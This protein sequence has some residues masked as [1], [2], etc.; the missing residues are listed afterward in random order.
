MAALSEQAINYDELVEDSG[1]GLRVSG[2]LYHDPQV[3]DDEMEKIFHQ[4][5]VFVGHDSEVAEP[6]EYITRNIGL[7]PVI[8]SRDSEGQVHLLLNR[9][10][11]RSATVCQQDRGNASTFTCAYHGWTYSNKG[12]LIGAPFNGGRGGYDE[13]FKREDYGLM[14]VPR[15]ASHRGFVFGSLSPTGQSFDDYLGLAKSY[16]D[17]F[18]D[19]APEGEVLARA[20]RQKTRYDGNWKLQVENLTDQYHVFFTHQTALRRPGRDATAITMD[21]ARMLQRDLGQG[22]TALDR[23]GANRS[24]GEALNDRITGATGTLDPEVVGRVAERMG[25]EAAEYVSTGGPPHIMVFPNLMVLWNAFRVLQPVRPNLSYIYYYPTFLK[26]ASDEINTQRLRAHENGFG[27]AGF[28]NPD[29]VDMFAR[30]QTGTKAKA[31]DWS[32]LHRGVR[33]EAMEPDDFGQPSLTTQVLGETNQRGIWRH[34]K[35]IMGQAG[36]GSGSNGPLTPEMQKAFDFYLA[37]HDA[38]VE[39]YN[40]KV[41]AIRG[42]EVLRVYDQ[43]LE[44]DMDTQHRGESGLVHLQRVSRDNKTPSFPAVAPRV[45]LP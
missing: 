45:R 26:G 7:Q 4:G 34:Y 2:R 9:C 37:N 43:Y 20:G 40:G 10:R 22:H 25:E 14:P 15:I 33:G 35:K 5:W 41:I 13:S 44:A 42:E 19:M 18:C 24:V 21:D 8:M 31:D 3:F 16:L 27:P 1:N 6:G 38:M 29:D 39:K 17:R 11:H 23:F 28:I 36:N 32:V 30:I 12:H